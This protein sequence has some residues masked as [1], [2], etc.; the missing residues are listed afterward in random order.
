[1]KTTLQRVYFH[2]QGEA[3]YNDAAGNVEATAH[4]SC[5]AKRKLA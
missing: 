1:M 5:V 4:F 3:I 2:A